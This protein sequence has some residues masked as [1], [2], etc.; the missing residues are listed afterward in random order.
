[1]KALILAPKSPRRRELLGRITAN[2]TVMTDD[3]EEVR[4]PGEAPSAMVCRLAQKKAE[5]VAQKVSGP[6]IILAADTVV[7]IGNRILGKPKNQADAREM[8]QTLS[9]N[10]H[11]VYTGFSILDTE[12]GKE[13]TDFEKS[14]VTFR[15]LSDTEAEAYIRTGEPMDKAGA[16][17]IQGI[18]SLFVSGLC[19]DYANVV[20]FPICKIGMV[21]NEEF[22]INLLETEG[23]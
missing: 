12:T 8:L 10:T 3:S 2:F 16:Y 6:S 22:G 18:G 5:N 14:E 21:L 23:R 7:A 9:G 11:A 1:M 17:G 15:S 20:G 19:G 4:I 13:F